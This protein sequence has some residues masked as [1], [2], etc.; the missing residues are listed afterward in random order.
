VSRT[1]DSIRDILGN[2]V[3]SLAPIDIAEPVRGALLVLKADLARNE[4]DLQTTG[5]ECPHLIDGD[6]DQLQLALIN[7][8]RNAIEAAGPE[9][10]VAVRVGADRY[11][12]EVEVADDG[13]GFP[14]GG[15]EI[16]SLLLASSKP[17]GTGI[18]LFVVRCAV[19]NHRGRIRIGRSDLGGASVVLRFP[20]IP[21]S[22]RR[23]R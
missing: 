9:G 16:E 20:P 11:A 5:L 1:I 14:G 2:V 13:P 12:V 19:E 17:E 4:I 6:R 18:G 3:S 10:H 22:R 23:Q 7:L 21:R 8:I 15:R